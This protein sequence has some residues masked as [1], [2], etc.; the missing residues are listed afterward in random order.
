M[1]PKSGITQLFAQDNLIHLQPDMNPMIKAKGRSRI[2][3]LGQICSIIIALLYFSCG[4]IEIGNGNSR[5]LQLPELVSGENY[6]VMV[7][8]PS[9]S[10]FEYSY[11]HDLNQIDTI[12]SSAGP[13]SYLPFP[14]NFGF[15]PILKNDDL[16]KVPVWILGTRQ[17]KGACMP[18]EILGLIDYTERG[19][20]HR[21]LLAL[22][23]NK[24]LQTIEAKSF[25]DFAIRY[26]PVK[27]MFEYWLKNRHGTGSVSQIVWQ[28]EGTAMEYI[29]EILNK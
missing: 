14:A 6:N 4:D 13:I 28:D 19:K 17:E 16:L 1:W 11:N 26:D 10:S 23:N 27:F 8:I 20:T 12:E 21:E 15:V 25:G 24:T 5:S 22:P 7:E 29:E 9:G 2:Q 18:V 3:R